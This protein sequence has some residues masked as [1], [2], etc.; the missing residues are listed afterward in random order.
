MK[1]C[2]SA[3]ADERVRSPHISGIRSICARVSRFIRIREVAASA[4]HPSE[5]S[6]MWRNCSIFGLHS[7]SNQCQCQC[8]VQHSWLLI[9]PIN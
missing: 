8:D 9:S 1:S 3:S 2:G 6:A 4:V 7:V 5:H